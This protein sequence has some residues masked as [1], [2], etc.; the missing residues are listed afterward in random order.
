MVHKMVSEL[1]MEIVVGCA[2]Y[3]NLVGSTATINRDVNVH[4]TMNLGV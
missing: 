1:R 4:D 2:E 3:N